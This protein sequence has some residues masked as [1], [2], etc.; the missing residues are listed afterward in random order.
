MVRY[1]DK[2]HCWSSST[3]SRIVSLH[4][5]T[6]YLM[7]SKRQLA[8]NKNE[9]LRVL[10]EDLAIGVGIPVLEMILHYIPQC[11]RFDI[12]E[13]LDCYPSTYITWVGYALIFSWFLVI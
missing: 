9:K 12:L 7:I 1:I 2:A 11:H 10:L 3:H 4:K 13:D 5:Q 8:I 6:L